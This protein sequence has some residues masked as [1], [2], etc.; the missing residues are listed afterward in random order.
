[1][2]HVE[3]S[4]I[5]TIVQLIR[6]CASGVI[7]QRIWEACLSLPARCVGSLSRAGRPRSVH[8]SSGDL[9]P[10]YDR[11]FGSESTSESVCLSRSLQS[12]LLANS[13]EFAFR[14]NNLPRSRRIAVLAFGRRC[15]PE[16]RGHSHQVWEGVGF[17]LLHGLSSVILYRVLADA[18]FPTHLFI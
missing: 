13:K 15:E 4:E 1:M 17:H 10:E 3:K 9:R 16:P 7:T 11:G 8:S 6:R 14:L 12:F 18:K 2:I 5:Q